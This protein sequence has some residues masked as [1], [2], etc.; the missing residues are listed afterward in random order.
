[1]A[2][3]LADAVRS[4]IKQHAPDERIP[5][6]SKNDRLFDTWHEYGCILVNPHTGQAIWYVT[7][8]GDVEHEDEAGQGDG[9]AYSHSLSMLRFPLE[10]L[11]DD[12]SQ[13][14]PPC[15][16]I[17]RSGIN[18]LSRAMRSKMRLNRLSPKHPKSRLPQICY[19]LKSK[20][21]SQRKTFQLNLLK[22][23]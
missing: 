10:K 9:A 17:S 12:A 23:R 2:K 22:Q 4:W 5:G 7:V 8:W 18:E 15:P 3:R 1:M 11:Y 21:L 20:N 19:R 14:P 13:Y 6:D 16:V